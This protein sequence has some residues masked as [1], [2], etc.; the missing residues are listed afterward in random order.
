MNTTND[1]IYKVN[2]R[3][4]NEVSPSA[5][6]GNPAVSATKGGDVRCRGLDGDLVDRVIEHKAGATWTRWGSLMDL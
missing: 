3:S 6:D 1:L 4:A 5:L 2:I